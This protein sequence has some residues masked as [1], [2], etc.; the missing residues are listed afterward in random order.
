MQVSRLSSNG[1]GLLPKKFTNKQVLYPITIPDSTE[2]ET[3]LQK[4]YDTLFKVD[5]GP[6][7]L[8]G[9]MIELN[10]YGYLFRL[11]ERNPNN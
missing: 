7:K 11:R 10:Y 9:V 2:L 4:D 8:E 3:L 6:V 5:E 1:P